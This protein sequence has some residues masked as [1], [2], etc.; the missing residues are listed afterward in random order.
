MMME[1]RFK[2]TSTEASY[3]EDSSPQ[4]L[5]GAERVAQAGVT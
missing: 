5:Q 4:G 3:G 1:V 2:T